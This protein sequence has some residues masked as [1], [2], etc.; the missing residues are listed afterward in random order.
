MPLDICISFGFG[1][2]KLRASCDKFS[3]SHHWVRA[4]CQ[5][6][7]AG[8]LQPRHCEALGP[9]TAPGKGSAASLCGTLPPLNMAI[10][11]YTGAWVTVQ[12]ITR[13][14]DEVKLHVRLHCSPFLLLESYPHGRSCLKGEFVWGFFL[15]PWNIWLHH[16]CRYFKFFIHVIPEL[17]LLLK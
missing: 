6:P 9:P 14:R 2:T 7:C 13:T 10:C 1:S 16:I 5:G 17:Y 3:E 8:G 15:L 11:I 12:S 4:N